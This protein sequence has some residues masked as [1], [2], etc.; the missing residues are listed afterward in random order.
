MQL[1]LDYKIEDKD[2]E[3]KETLKLKLKEEFAQ[4]IAKRLEIK[5]ENN[6]LRIDAHIYSDEQIKRVLR[7]LSYDMAN[8][9]S[10]EVL[11]ILKTSEL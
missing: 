2:L 7:L 11:N 5:E 3:F 1:R 9:T 6:H 8:I 10:V 4:E